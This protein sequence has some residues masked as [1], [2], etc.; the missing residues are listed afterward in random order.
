MADGT[1]RTWGRN[2]F[3]Q[4][5]DGT[6]TNRTRPVPV[7]GLTD[8]ED[9][10]GGQNYSVALVSGVV[11]P[12]ES[13]PTAPGRPAG[14]STSPGTIDLTWAAAFD[15]VSSTLTYHV[16]RDG[17]EVGAPTSAAPTVSFTDAGLEGGATHTYTIVAEDGASNY[18][19]PSEPSEP[20]TVLS[21]PPVIFSDD[22]SSGTLGRWTPVTRFAIDVGAGSSSP[23]SARASVMGQTATMVRNLGSGFSTICVSARVNVAARTGS[24]ILWRLRTAADGPIARVLVNDSGILAIRSDVSGVTRA[25]GV[26][27]GSGWHTIELCGAV[28]TAGLWDL[29]RDGVRIVNA[30]AANTGTGLIARLELGNSNAATWTA[31]FDDVQVDQVAG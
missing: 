27:L 18:G 26:A 21:G 16:L 8:V 11:E 31:N 22:F 28:G 7:P 6:T 5:G 24:M 30:W 4:L 2:D 29:F 17:T 9:V 19:P 1:V 20:I 14:E 25:S 3:G 10:H 23:P 15:E 13:P 12:D